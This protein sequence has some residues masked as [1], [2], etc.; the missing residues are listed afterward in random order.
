[1]SV[2]RDLAFC[3]PCYRIS[4]GTPKM[5]GNPRV[6][7]GGHGD[8]RQDL[9]QALIAA[10]PRPARFLWE[11]AV[12]ARPARQSRRHQA[13]LPLVASPKSLLLPM[14]YLYSPSTCSVA[15]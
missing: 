8:L 14:D 7:H 1:M 3:L 15:S 12:D 6:G 10:P 11:T 4:A 5:A 2:H 9:H 13:M